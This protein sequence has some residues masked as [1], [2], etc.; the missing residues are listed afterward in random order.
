MDVGT[1]VPVLLHVSLCVQARAC[2]VGVCVPICVVVG[3]QAL[4][5]AHSSR[6]EEAHT[7]FP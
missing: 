3:S 7:S 4:L 5:T 1:A 6:R 2:V